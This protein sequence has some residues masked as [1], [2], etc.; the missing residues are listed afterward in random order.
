MGGKGGRQCFRRLVVKRPIQ[1]A[2]HAQR[3][4]TVCFRNQPSDMALIAHEHD[5][6]LVAF[7]RVENSTEVAG[8]VSYGQ[9]LHAIRLS[10]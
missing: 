7:E 8:D 10:D 2:K 5:L 3:V 1:I 9:R 6:F 4:L